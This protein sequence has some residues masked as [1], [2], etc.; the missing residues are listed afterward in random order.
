MSART[1]D[2]PGTG[3]EHDVVELPA[4]RVDDAVALWAAAGLTR[5][6]ND[7]RHDCR[8]ALDA[9]ASTV[10]ALFGAPEEAAGAAE[11]AGVPGRLLG[12]IMVGH[13]G[14]RGW[15]YYLAVA[16]DRRGRG[17]GET[18]VRAAEEWLRERGT[19]KMMLMVR[20][21]NEGVLSFYQRLGYLEQE[22]VTLG[23]HL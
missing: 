16:A 15:V 4:E 18:L 17:F 13:D 23:R 1:V 14:H 12:T 20:R 10:L 21:E 11:D 5:P 19:P 6:W 3:L 8:R 2:E 22:V 7:P 9:P